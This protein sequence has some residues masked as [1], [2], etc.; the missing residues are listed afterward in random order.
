VHV[1]EEHTIVVSH[2]SADLKDSC[3]IEYPCPASNARVSAFKKP[4]MS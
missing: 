3:L 2:I 4:R 1:L